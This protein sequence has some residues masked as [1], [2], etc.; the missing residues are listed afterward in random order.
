MKIGFIGGGNMA[1]AIIGGLL[2]QGQIPTEIGVVEIQPAQRERL[3]ALGVQTFESIGDAFSICEVVVLAVKPQQLR[4][5]A[6]MLAPHL[7]N[8][9]VVS[10]AAGV[11]SSDLQRWLDGHSRIVRTM[12]NTPALVGRGLTAL[13]A[14]PGLGPAD[15]ERSDRLLSA[16]GTTLWV[17]DEQRL[18]AVTAVSGSGPAYVFLFLEAL[19][20]AA[21]T[22][23]FE[24]DEARRLALETCSGACLLA[25]R[26]GEPFERLRAQVT[27]K[28][29][30]TER[31]IAVLES[32]GVAA[33]IVEA[34]QAAE[35]RAREL[36]DL[37]GQD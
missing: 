27:S 1:Q 37:L 25:E 12:P 11:R 16:V 31:A 18:D 4:E 6:R 30:T 7:R 21:E 35:A 36:G 23:G 5:V 17:E 24:S 29:G 22:L 26:G 9:L 14:M 10:I 32:A 2:Q 13:H 20:R 3:A 33:S 19:Q 15:R 8:T 28:G 34:I